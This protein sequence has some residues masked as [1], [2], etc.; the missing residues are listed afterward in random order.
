M[1]KQRDR[2]DKKE[3]KGEEE[4]G[5][6]KERTSPSAILDL[7]ALKVRLVLDDFDET[8]HE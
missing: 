2:E 3:G 7:V 4:R 6:E 5:R 8:L 1:K